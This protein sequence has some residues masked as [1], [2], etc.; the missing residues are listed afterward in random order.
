VVAGLKGFAG[1]QVT[2]KNANGPGSV[3][4]DDQ[5]HRLLDGQCSHAYA[6]GFSLY[7]LYGQAAGFAGRAP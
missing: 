7:K 3:L 6:R 2:G 1:S 5:A 4:T